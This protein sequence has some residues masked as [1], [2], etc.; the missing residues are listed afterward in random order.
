MT[1]TNFSE[2]T[3]HG[4]LSAMSWLDSLNPFGAQPGEHAARPAPPA[5]PQQ[6][7]ASAPIAPGDASE[8]VERQ[9]WEL[10]ALQQVR[11]RARARTCTSSW[12]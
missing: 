2:S 5:L 12:V 7:A 8:T 4:A 3:R 9:H 6:V 11:A 10:L 1:V